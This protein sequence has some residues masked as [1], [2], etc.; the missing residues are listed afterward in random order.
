MVRR[1][2]FRRKISFC[3]IAAGRMKIAVFHASSSRT[4]HAAPLRPSA[5]TNRA[6]SADASPHAIAIVSDHLNTDFGGAAITRGQV[7]KALG[8]I[9]TS[10]HVGS[11]ALDPGAARDSGLHKA[12]R[13]CR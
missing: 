3:T 13:Q 5:F 12:I 4:E 2:D 11:Y 6:G 7:L 1:P 8:Q 9:Q 10:D